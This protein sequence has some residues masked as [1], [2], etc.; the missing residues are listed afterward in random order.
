MEVLAREQRT[1][2]A[3]ILSLPD[4][5]LGLVSN[6]LEDINWLKYVSHIKFAGCSSNSADRLPGGIVFSGR[7]QHAE[8]FIGFSGRGSGTSK[9]TS[10]HL[11][12]LHRG[13]KV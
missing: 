4:E 7:P 1:S 10:L 5:L 9:V 12:Y 6:Y 8:I 11:A 13:C 3:T 2:V